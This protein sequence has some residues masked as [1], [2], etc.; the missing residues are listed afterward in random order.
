MTAID[1]PPSATDEHADLGS[2]G[3]NLPHVASGG[4][5]VQ[6]PLSVQTG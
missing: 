2:G 6:P 3:A 1:R 4:T 5:Y